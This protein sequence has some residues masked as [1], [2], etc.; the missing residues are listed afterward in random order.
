[1]LITLTGGEVEGNISKFM[2]F[3][4]DCNIILTKIFFRYTVD[5]SSSDVE[6]ALAE[7]GILKNVSKSKGNLNAIYENDGKKISTLP[8]LKLNKDIMWT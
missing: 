4:L 7:I 3:S 1:M 2:K 5:V 6:N 8:N